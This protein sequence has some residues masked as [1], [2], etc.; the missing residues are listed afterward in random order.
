MHPK[1]MMKRSIALEAIADV[2]GNM[3]KEG[4]DKVQVTNFIIGAKEKL[5][6]DLPDL[7]ARAKA[8]A[9]A[10]RWNQK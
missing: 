2:A 3:E 8:K 4:A 1:D 9:A 7:E 5:A 10:E 6:E